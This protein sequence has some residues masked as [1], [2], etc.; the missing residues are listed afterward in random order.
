MTVQK[1]YNNLAKL[2]T[3]QIAVDCLNETKESIADLNAEQMF[4]GLRADQTPILPSYKDITIEIKKLKGQVTDR[5]TLYSTGDFYRGLQT[6]ITQNSVI[7]TS[8]DYKTAKLEKK[9]ATKKGPLFGI[10]GEFKERFIS[11]KLRP[12]FNKRMQKETGLLMK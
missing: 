5:V 7:T 2:N 12:A 6:T 11:Q 10:G 9:Y 8:T 3:D 4:T 1:L